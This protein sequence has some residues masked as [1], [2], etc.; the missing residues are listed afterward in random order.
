MG[1]PRKEDADKRK[2]VSVRF[3]PLVHQLLAEQARKNGRGLSA[4]IEARVLQTL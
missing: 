4:E 1:R 2:L 3:G